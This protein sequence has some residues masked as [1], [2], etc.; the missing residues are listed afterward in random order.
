MKVDSMC[1]IGKNAFVNTISQC[2]FSVVAGRI[3]IAPSSQPTESRNSQ[4]E[5][6]QHHSRRS[7]TDAEV[8]TSLSEQFLQAASLSDTR[9]LKRST[10]VFRNRCAVTR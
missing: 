7:L 1:K 8:L 4:L 9:R 10:A 3:T 2:K 5:A 6:E